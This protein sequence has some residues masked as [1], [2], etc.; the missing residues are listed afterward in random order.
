MLVVRRF[1][2]GLDMDMSSEEVQRGPLP[3]LFERRHQTGFGSFDFPLPAFYANH[4]GHDSDRLA[5]SG[6]PNGRNVFATIAVNDFQHK[7]SQP[8]GLSF[9]INEAGSIAV[10]AV[11]AI[12]TAGTV[13]AG[14]LAGISF[15]F[16]YSCALLVWVYYR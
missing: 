6:R 13:A 14:A 10:K 2:F 3:L 9:A 11:A 8:T 5:A 12:I 15:H 7:R 1:S 16:D 4:T